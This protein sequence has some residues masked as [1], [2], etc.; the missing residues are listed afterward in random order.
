V[1]SWRSHGTELPES[2]KIQHEVAKHLA[3][4]DEGKSSTAE[5]KAQSLKCN[6]DPTIHNKEK[7]KLHRYQVMVTPVRANLHQVMVEPVDETAESETLQRSKS[8]YNDGLHE[9]DSSS[10][11]EDD[12][13]FSDDS[14]DGQF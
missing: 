4:G 9:D 7:Q 10:E 2:A 12:S 13:S 14:L 11:V 3:V 6:F 8:D 5:P 1:W